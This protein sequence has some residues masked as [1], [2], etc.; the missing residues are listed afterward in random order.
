MAAEVIIAPEAQQDMDEA[1]CWY[2]D[3]RPGLGE[4]FYEYAG[5]QVTIYCIFHTSRDPKKWHNRLV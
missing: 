2:E 3:R 4:E 1:Y 5:G